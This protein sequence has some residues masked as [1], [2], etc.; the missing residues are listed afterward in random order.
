MQIL[1][2]ELKKLFKNRAIIIALAVFLLLDL[3]NIYRNY[4]ISNGLEDY[5]VNALLKI[6]TQLDGE[7]TQDKAD[8]I[9]SKVNELELL[10]S[11]EFQ[12]QNE[13]DN[14]FDTG[15]AFW[16]LQLWSTYDNYLNKADEFRQSSEYKLES[17]L[18]NKEFF[19]GKNEFYTLANQL[20]YD[21][22][23]GRKITTI[24]DTDRLP[25]YF[26]YN[27]SSVLTVVILLLGII[28][29]FCNECE[30]D[31]DIVLQTSTN[32]R[33]KSVNA[34]IITS[35]LFSFVATLVFFVTDFV[36]F[37]TFD[38]LDGLNQYV[39]AVQGYDNISLDIKVW[40]FIILQFVFRL[41]GMLIISL[42]FLL[43]SRIFKKSAAPF[44][45]GLGYFFLVILCRVFLTNQ[46]GD[47]LNLFNPISMI[48]SYKSLSKFD[49][50]NLF[51]HPVFMWQLMI[52][53]GLI[54]IGVLYLIILCLPLRFEL[55]VRHGK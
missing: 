50:V 51:N 31:M 1:G 24:Y 43:L 19:K 10:Y 28:P 13:P 26:E 38:R 44:V 45:C 3:F 18:K 30:C 39:Y 5:Y 41:M 7:L 20:Y 27:F 54:I 37:M 17:S 9:R 47:I 53:V 22:Y 55:K 49:I 35:L 46:A 40:Q 12:N 21:T 32:G 52:F 42:V 4:N 11:G 23:S 48:V 36:G 15:Y 33:R 16:D 29:I 34:K 14:R 25:E 8:L 2:S 6:E